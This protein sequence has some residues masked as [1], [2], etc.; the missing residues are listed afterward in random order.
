MHVQQLLSLLLGD[1]VFVLL[2]LALN[3]KITFNSAVTGEVLAHQYRILIL[4]N[5]PSS[6]FILCI[7]MFYSLYGIIATNTAFV[8]AWQIGT[9]T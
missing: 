3:C 7:A 6:R 9:P 4:Y 2:L 1:F 5:C 8:L